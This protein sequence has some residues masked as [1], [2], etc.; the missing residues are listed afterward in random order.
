MSFDKSSPSEGT[1]SYLKEIGFLMVRGG[2]RHYE[3]AIEEEESLGRANDF[4]SFLRTNESR[5]WERD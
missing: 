2:R 4:M 1:S 3:I 5:H